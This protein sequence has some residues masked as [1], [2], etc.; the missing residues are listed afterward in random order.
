MLMLLLQ[1]SAAATAA[2]AQ[3]V[4]VTDTSIKT[5][6]DAF[7]DQA[8]LVAVTVWALQMLKRSRLFPWLNA[9]TATATSVASTVVAL[10][11]A[12]AVQIHVTGSAAL[13]WQGSFAIPNAHILWT[14][15]IHFIDQKI[16]QKKLYKF[17][18]KEPLEITPVPAPPMDAGGKP[19]EVKV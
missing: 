5:T 7:T 13:G 2:V 14:G 1:S 11:A 9:N 3:A 8:G 6:V 15:L 19:V 18:Y 12:M 4:P 16:K 10:L 17:L